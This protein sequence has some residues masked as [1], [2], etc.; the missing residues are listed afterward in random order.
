MAFQP[1]YITI[2]YCIVA[3]HKPGVIN[4]LLLTGGLLFISNLIAGCLQFSVT[5]VG[6][7]LIWSYLKNL[8]QNF[9]ISMKKNNI[10]YECYSYISA[11]T[12]AV[13]Y[14]ATM[15]L[16]TIE[17]EN[18]PLYTM[19]E[20]FIAYIL[21]A[22]LV[23][24]IPIKHGLRNLKEESIQSSYI[25][26]FILSIFALSQ[27]AVLIANLLL[28]KTSLFL[29]SAQKEELP[30]QSQKQGVISHILSHK[31]SRRIFLFLM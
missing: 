26:V 7:A 17:Q 28:T 4:E 18:Q 13:L 8:D 15:I 5:E 11:G 12:I 31:D 19:I 3:Y 24:K 29:Y 6:L 2:N 14:K 22:F 25:I 23:F 9:T 21:I 30:L 16:T 10:K 1:A 27:P 20:V